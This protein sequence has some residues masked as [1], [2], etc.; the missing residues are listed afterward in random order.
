MD[1]LLVNLR[2]YR[3]RDNT[4]PLENFVT[5]AFA[6]LLRSS[7]EVRK[8]VFIR[9][10]LALQSPCDFPQDECVVSTQEN[11]SGKF[12][13]L[14]VS[15]PGCTWVFEHKVWS[16]LHSNQLKSYRDYI[17]SHSDDY[18]L[19]LITAKTYQHAQNPDAALCWEDIYHCLHKLE[20]NTN[21]EQLSWALNDFLTLLK[22][23]GLGPSTPINRFAMS[24]YLEAIKFDS[25]VDSVFKQAEQ[26]KWPLLSLD[27]KPLFKRQKTESRVGL[28]FSPEFGEHGRRWLPSIFCGVLLDGGDHGVTEFINDELNLCFV[29]DFNKLGQAYISGSDTYQDF[30]SDL[31]ELVKEK[32]CQWQFIDTALE[33]KARYNRWHPI[34]LLTP[35]LPIFKDTHTHQEQV[36]V[37]HTLFSEIQTQL[38]SLN[39]FRN[40]VTELALL[41]DKI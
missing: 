19:I 8:A 28:E 9:I 37:V 36:D 22:T 5:E 14:V 35:M 7:E 6:W 3:P 12:P 29:F 31:S 40:L 18:R 21:D 15:W 32:F 4:D 34:V 26:L 13:D 41:K 16:H 33:P 38:L 20:Q 25:Q 27:I 39:S 11:F 23:E 30:K 24:H 17:E 2:K 1:S 10:N